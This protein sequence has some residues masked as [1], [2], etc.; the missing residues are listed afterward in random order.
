MKMVIALKPNLV[1]AHEIIKHGYFGDVEAFVDALEPHVFKGDTC[2]DDYC[3]WVMDEESNITQRGTARGYYDKTICIAHNSRGYDS[4]FVLKYLEPKSLIPETL[5]ANGGSS[6]QY[7][8]NMV[9]LFRLL[10]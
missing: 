3:Q 5:R 4:R 7:L 9:E 10:A 6:V 1:I 2:V 8:L